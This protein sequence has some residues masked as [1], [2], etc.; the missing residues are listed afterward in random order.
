MLYLHFPETLL[1]L[2]I[3]TSVQIRGDDVISI[4]GQTDTMLFILM[5]LNN[6]VFG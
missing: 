2:Q 3:S 6:D 5:V 1:I 4:G